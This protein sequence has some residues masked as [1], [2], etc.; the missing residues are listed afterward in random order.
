MLY[1]C[2]VT[3]CNYLSVMHLFNCNVN[4]V[5]TLCSIITQHNYIMYVIMLL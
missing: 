2:N 5:I 4:D 3:L 1:K